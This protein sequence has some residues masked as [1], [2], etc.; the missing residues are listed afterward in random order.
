MEDVDGMTGGVGW[1]KEAQADS[2]FQMS[3]LH[4]GHMVH[5]DNRMDHEGYASDSSDHDTHHRSV[6]AAGLLTP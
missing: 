4:Q 5:Q 2:P 1:R 6:T 3:L